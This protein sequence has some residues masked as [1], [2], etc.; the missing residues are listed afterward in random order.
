MNE[1]LRIV[2][3]NFSVWLAIALA[4]W[5]ITIWS[6]P[7][8]TWDEA[9]YYPTFRDV[10]GWV[11]MLLGDPALALCAEGIA[12]GWE[13]IHEL[14]PLLKWLGA[15]VISPEPTGPSTLRWMRLIP[16]GA[17]AL[18]LLLLHSIA[19]RWGGWRMGVLA[20]GLY[21]VHPRIAGHAQLAASETLFAAITVLTLWVA[22]RMKDDRR[23]CAAL[24]L[25][26][27]AAL[28]T[29][30]NAL[31]LFT[32][33]VGWIVFRRSLRRGASVFPGRGPLRTVALLLIGAPLVAFALWPW[34][35]PDPVARIRGYYEF[36]AQHSH[37]PL[38]FM[39]EKTN[40]GDSRAPAWY[41]L[42][43]F[44]VTAPVLWLGMVLGGLVAVIV[45]AVRRRRLP[46]VESL[47]L[48]AALAPLLGSCL[49]SAPKYDGIR[50]FLPMY[51]PL[52]LLVVRGWWLLSLRWRPSRRSLLLLVLPLTALLTALTLRDRPLLSYYE[53]YVEW[54]APTPQEFPFERTYWG[55]AMTPEVLRELNTLLPPNAR[56]K[57]LAL[58]VDTFT[59]LQEWGML[60]ADL[61]FSAEPPYDAHLL[62]NRR[63]FWGNAEW[64]IFLHR[65]PIAAWPATGAEPLVFLYDGRPPGSR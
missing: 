8:L 9:Y 59:I 51:A 47:L 48:L 22:L 60:R 43:M 27:G 28:A 14:P 10:R 6:S 58:Q 57:T 30:I 29:K 20:A 46:M 63:G 49:P 41:P 45:T 23:W 54:T 64:D 15:L 65:T 1:R 25:C 38:W 7:G 35:W 17:F 40:W 5:G 13:R 37:Q 39:G 2:A 34:L 31:F 26:G 21:A 61:Q 52:V 24:L 16:A 55:D 32:A 53:A 12:A 50:L 33:V 18:T 62:Q 19:R 56:V 44:V 11:G 3:I 42:V 4:W 36:V